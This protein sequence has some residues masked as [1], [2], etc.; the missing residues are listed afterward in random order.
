MAG[1][2]RYR[3]PLAHPMSLAEIT[4]GRYRAAVQVPLP[5]QPG[6]WRDGW[7]DSPMEAL[8]ALVD[9]LVTELLTNGR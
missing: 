9:Q 1:D 7:G 8:E 6:A 3:N 4:P 5:G 2:T